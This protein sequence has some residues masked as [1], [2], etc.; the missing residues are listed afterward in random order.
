MKAISNPYVG[1]EGYHCFAC[2]PDSE[3]GLRMRFHK[4]GE[5]VVCR[6]QPRQELEGYTGVLHGG[7]QTTLMDEIASWWVF[8]NRGTAGATAHLDVDFRRPVLRR[9]L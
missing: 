3:I 8:V 4:D 6:W 5:D 1:R 7:I 9:A 2:S